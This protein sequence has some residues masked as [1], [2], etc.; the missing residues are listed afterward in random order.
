[1]ELQTETRDPEYKFGHCDVCGARL[2]VP[3]NSFGR[4]ECDCG[5]RYYNLTGELARD[6]LLR[7]MDHSPVVQRRRRR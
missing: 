6:E 2:R 5:A 3:A 1:M 7:A 4:T